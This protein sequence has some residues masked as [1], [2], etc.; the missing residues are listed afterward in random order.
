MCTIVLHPDSRS[1][2]AIEPLTRE[3]WNAIRYD[4][5]VG[6]MVPSP[7][8]RKVVT[9]KHT[10]TGD[11]TEIY[12]MYVKAAK[13]KL[14]VGIHFRSGGGGA[15][16]QPFTAWK[17]KVGLMMQGT[18][19]MPD[20][21]DV[22]SA[23]ATSDAALF[24]PAFLDRWNV[25]DITSPAFRTLISHT[26]GKGGTW[27]F[28]DYKGRVH[29]VGAGDYMNTTRTLHGVRVFGTI[30]EA[31]LP[32]A[33]RQQ[34]PRYFSYDRPA[35]TDGGAQNGCRCIPCSIAR[36]RH[37]LVNHLYAYALPSPTDTR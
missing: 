20:R 15:Y 29:P 17:G 19:I 6:I 23:P 27:L 9:A 4:R 30:P 2:P 34:Y 36:Q 13:K 14:P 21:S 5:P 8:L 10:T 31:L 33:Q 22:L 28:M 7:H 1:G 11:D 12:E 32:H 18:G 26:A 25:R 3:E 37:D 16:T 35:N 24:G